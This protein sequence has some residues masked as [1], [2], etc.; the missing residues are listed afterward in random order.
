MLL[1]GII[2]MFVALLDFSGMRLDERLERLLYV[3]EGQP[4]FVE[5]AETSKVEPV[6][7]PTP[8][9]SSDT[10]ASLDDIELALSEIYNGGHK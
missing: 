8:A 6:K 5:A 2:A 10:D 3:M 4:E 7:A 1:M 9:V